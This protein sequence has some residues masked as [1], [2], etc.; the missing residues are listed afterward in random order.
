MVI[1][2]V[3]MQAHPEK[4]LELKQTLIALSE[5]TRKEK[6]CLHYSIFQDIERDNSFS[7]VMHWESREDLDA[8]LSSNEFAVLMG[9]RSLLRSSPEIMI[10][11]VSESS[12]LKYERRQ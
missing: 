7:L 1:V 6:S 12:A 2:I 4:F 10:N 3:R 5:A 11:T 8:H 9:T